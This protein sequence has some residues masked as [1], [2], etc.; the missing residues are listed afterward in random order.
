LLLS[1]ERRRFERGVLG[2]I[3]PVNTRK[4]FSTVTFGRLGK[5]GRIIEEDF[6]KEDF[7]F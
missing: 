4:K 7:K 2:G 5:R 3:L 1:S 6:T